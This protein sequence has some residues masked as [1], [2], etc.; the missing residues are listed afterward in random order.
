MVRSIRSR[1]L[2][3]FFVL[4]FAT[5]WA[6]WV[7]RAA[8]VPMGAVGQLWTWVPAAAALLAAALTG[9]CG[10]GARGAP[11]ALAR[12]LAMVRGGHPRACGFLAGSGGRLRAA[13]RILGGRRTTG[14]ARRDAL[15]ARARLLG[16]AVPHRRP[17]RGASLAGVRAP[18]AAHRPQRSGGEPDPRGA[19][20][21]VAPPAGVDR[22]C[23]A[24]PTARLAALLGHAGQVGPVHLGVL[25]HTRQRTL[26]R[27]LARHDQ[28][29]RRLPGGR[30]GRERGAPPSRGVGQVGLGGRGDRSSGSRSR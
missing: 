5:T 2:V 22:R 27:A 26:G 8:G 1:P 30:R 16:G 11:G 15:G 20:V 18:A 4:P 3:A 17:G 14:A 28:P 10:G 21:G 13:R 23:P 29:F 24:P 6:V 12:W 7:P 9:G 19:L 25:A